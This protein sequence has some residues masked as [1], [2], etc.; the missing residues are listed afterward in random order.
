MLRARHRESGRDGFHPP[1][2]LPSSFPAVLDP[3]SRRLVAH[4]ES[5]AEIAR[6]SDDIP[7]GIV[8]RES[9]E[10][11]CA[12]CGIN[13]AHEMVSV[14]PEGDRKLLLRS[15]FCVTCSESMNAEND[16]DERARLIARFTDPSYNGIPLSMTGWSAETYPKDGSGQQARRVASEWLAEYREGVRRNLYLHGEV[17]AGKTGLAVAIA[18]RL[19]EEGTSA[20]FANWRDLLADVRQS[21][22]LPDDPEPVS[23]IRARTFSVLVLDDIGAER[24]TEWA[25]EELAGLVQRRRDASLPIVVTS[26]YSPE[27][28]LTYFGND[29]GAGRILDR[30]LD[31]ATVHKVG[32]SSRRLGIFRR[33]A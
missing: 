32:G 22:R 19:T 9:T 13:G 4:D 24:P 18:K 10:Q 11:M 33:K 1:S 17:G 27:A 3:D 26:N 15:P 20:Y 12:G 23:V 2:D 30:L 14:G 5:I 7:T 21:F 28:L 31:D 8:H 6:L 25:L 16:A 29:V